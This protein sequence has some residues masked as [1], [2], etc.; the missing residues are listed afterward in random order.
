MTLDPATYFIDD[1][2]EVS[3]YGFTITIACQAHEDE[4]QW[5]VSLVDNVSGQA[6]QLPAVSRGHAV[7]Q[8]RT[9]FRWAS[10]VDNVDELWLKGLVSDQWMLEA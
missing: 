7:D 5:L 1:S 2:Q 4:P 10:Q 6:R 9:C 3:V 8:A